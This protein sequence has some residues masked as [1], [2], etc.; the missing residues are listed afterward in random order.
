MYTAKGVDDGV[1]QCLEPAT[2]LALGMLVQTKKEKFSIFTEL[3]FFLETCLTKSHEGTQG[4]ESHS[5]EKRMVF[6]LS[7]FHDV[8]IREI[9]GADLVETVSVLYAVL[10]TMYGIYIYISPPP[11]AGRPS[12]R[13]ICTHG[14]RR[15]VAQPAGCIC[16]YIVI[17]KFPTQLPH[18]AEQ[19]CIYIC[20]YIDVYIYI[21]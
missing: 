14:W 16:I 5:R 12:A 1:L 21:L 17:C 7:N 11:R 15:A 9:C 8:M 20:I 13:G 6:T 10:G 18:V 19:H 2:L 4:V 3:L